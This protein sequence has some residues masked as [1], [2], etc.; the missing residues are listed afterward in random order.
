MFRL[1]SREGAGRRQHVPE[2]QGGV[3]GVA[4]EWEPGQDCQPARA[5]DPAQDKPA[6]HQGVSCVLVRGRRGNL[7]WRYSDP[8][9]PSGSHHL[10]T[11]LK[12]ASDNTVSLAAYK[13]TLTKTKLLSSGS[14]HLSLLDSL[15]GNV[16]DVLKFSFSTVFKTNKEMQFVNSF[17]KDCDIKNSNIFLQEGNINLCC[18][19][20]LK[21]NSSK[22]RSCDNSQ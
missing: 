5:R 12:V 2:Q 22:F 19:V 21:S 15:S 14:T 11:L 9:K 16:T 3:Q 8:L 7:L 1:P 13:E 20:Y 6:L 17:I 4:G 10:E 18:D